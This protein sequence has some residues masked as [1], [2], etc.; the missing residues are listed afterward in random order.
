MQ[1]NNELVKKVQESASVEIINNFVSE[2][3]TI[4]NKFK[5]VS[6]TLPPVKDDASAEV[7]SK[8]LGKADTRFKEIQEKRKSIT[9]NLDAVKKGLMPFE[10]MLDKNNSDSIVYNIKK[11]LDQFVQQ[12]HHEA[13][14]QR[15][16]LVKKQQKADQLIEC[17][18]AIKAAINSILVDFMI[19]AD[20]RLQSWFLGLTLANIDASVEKLKQ[21]KPLDNK[22]YLK[23]LNSVSLQSFTALSPE[24][25]DECR[26]EVSSTLTYEHV[27][28]GFTKAMRVMKDKY[29]EKKDERINYLKELEA[30]DV[31][32]KSRIEAAENERIAE[33]TRKANEFME[34][35]RKS[36][37]EEIKQEVIEET[38]AQTFQNQAAEQTIEDVDNT[39]SSM[40]YS[41]S[42]GVLEDP[43]RLLEAMQMLATNVM[44]NAKFDPIQRTRE[45]FPVKEKGVTKLVPGLQYWL[46]Q[47]AKLKLEISHDSIQC[48]KVVKA[49]IVK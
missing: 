39:V 7:A 42:P 22:V 32:E 20:K 49:K 45:G 6:D 36:R 21:D 11:D 15:A 31:A 27:N 10:K 47:A 28:T 2:S 18:A 38:V 35:Q 34:E 30:A 41:L 48:D 1:D 16:E 8:F 43:P 13:E 24:D 5:S 37:Q 29:I 4:V 12:K 25:L 14:K 44:M 9:S 40:V 46:D 3:E 33:E 17:K 23:A 26:K 19:D